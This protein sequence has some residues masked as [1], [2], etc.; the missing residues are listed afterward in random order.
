MVRLVLWDVDGTL[1]HSRGI[2]SA[3]FDR[4]FEQ[5]L[6]QVPTAR[7]NQRIR[8]SG[9]TDPQIALEYLTLMQIKDPESH[10][11]PVLELLAAEVAA[12]AELLA[13]QGESL[14]GVPELLARLA[15]ADGVHQTLLTGNLA[16]NAA[17][18]VAAFGLDGWLDLEIGAY[19]SDHADRCELVPIAL[20][21]ARR[22]R[23]LDVA[24]A[25]TWVV[26]DTE[27]DWACAQAGGVRS[28][29]VATGGSSLEELAAL[30]PDAVLD[31]LSD[32]DTVFK[33]LTS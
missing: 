29:L 31:D 1:I 17:V 24:P 3:V 30:E 7:I 4:A 13:A 21:R 12:V 10:I 19:G 33:L 27:R 26:G 20:E 11:P 8:L 32:V 16:A 14:P 25:D 22:L 6:G 5:L 2:G 28:L 9:K 23:H 15:E 18:K